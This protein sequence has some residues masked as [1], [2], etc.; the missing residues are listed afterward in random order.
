MSNRQER[1][2]RKQDKRSEK[3]LN[4]AWAYMDSVAENDYSVHTARVIMLEAVHGKQRA[5]EINAVCPCSECREGDE[6]R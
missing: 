1:R 2:E 6:W 4:A 3:A 5:A